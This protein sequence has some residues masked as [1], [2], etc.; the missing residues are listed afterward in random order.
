MESRTFR[1]FY[2]KE[3]ADAFAQLLSDSDIE[4]E[5]VQDKETLDS[6][7]GEKVFKQQFYVKLKK[8]DFDRADSLLLDETAKELDNVA[9]D[10]YLHNF[11]D[12]ELFDVVSKPD[13]WNE[14]D[15][16]L[17]QRILQERGTVINSNT[18]D[19]LKRQRLNE[20][21]KT[22]EGQRNWIYAGYI[23]AILG[24]LLG[25]FI[26]WHLYAFKKT[27][28]N[29]ERV[30]GYSESDRRHGRRILIIG[31]VMFIVWIGV[32]LRYD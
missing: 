6:L 29:G 30:F 19:L 18:I 31:L 9:K 24:G 4:F 2:E 16:Q 11:T 20:L 27:L 26:G 25:L 21:G 7:Y 10:H 3:Q 23:F 12:D 17:S 1:K 8:T 32:R 22:A 13:E 5:I 14:L 28:P 15:Y